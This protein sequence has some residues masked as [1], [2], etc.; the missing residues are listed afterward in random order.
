MCISGYH[1]IRM[2]RL[3]RKGLAELSELDK[4]LLL[5]RNR[6]M[7]RRVAEKTQKSLSTVSRVYWG[8][9]K[10]SDTVFPVLNQEVRR[11]SAQPLQIRE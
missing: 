3:R 1:T 11:L 5:A 6:G 4:L 10:R 2:Q 9:V 7:L 8:R